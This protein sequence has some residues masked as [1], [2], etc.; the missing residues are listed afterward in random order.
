MSKAYDARIDAQGTPV[1]P[2]DP[3]DF[4]YDG[5]AEYEAGCTRRCREFWESGSGVLVHRRFRVPEVYSYGCRDMQHSLAWQLGALAQSVHYKGDVA[6][7]LEPWYG[8]GTIASCYGIEY[9]WADGQAPASHPPFQTLAGALSHRPLPADQT[10]IGRHT[11]RMIDY[12]VQSTEGRL[13]IS[14]TD[15]QS[16]WNIAAMA[17]MASSFLIEVIENPEGVRELVNRTADL[18][19]DFTRKQLDLLGDTVVWP[20]H[21]FASSRV[22]SG[23]G[24]SDDNTLMISPAQYTELVAP[25]TGR[26]GSQFG[27]AVFHSCGNWSKWLK[28]VQ[29]IP[30]LIMSDG[31]FSAQTDPAPNA[32]EPFAEALAGAGVVLN[33]RVVGDPDVVA[34]TVRKLWRPGMRLI[35][36]T[37]C[38]TPE[39]QAEAYDRIHEICGE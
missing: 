17:V 18:L 15:T 1:E 12:F 27:G 33:A 19:L 2:L 3:S 25:I 37:Y 21:G 6:N 13:P 35:V 9:V 32:P 20:G 29:S 28:A 38:Q 16:P 5:F 14:L 10:P 22:F 30:G 8:I 26:V 11:L 7:F 36:V 24:M 34:R 23:L 4:D 31:A 39:Q